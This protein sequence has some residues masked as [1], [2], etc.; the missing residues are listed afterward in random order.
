MR[1]ARAPLRA[2]PALLAVALAACTSTG[3]SPRPDGQDSAEDAL[4]LEP[5]PPPPLAAR[6]P[7]LE[8]RER[9]AELRVFRFELARDET[10]RLEDFDGEVRVIASEREVPEVFAHLG[11]LASSRETAERKLADIRFE[12]ALEKGERVLRL[13]E[14]VDERILTHSSYDVW[15]PFGTRVR[16]DTSAGG[17]RLTGPLG[18]CAVTASG[19][20][21]HVTDVRGRLIVR[22]SAEPVTIRSVE[23]PKLRV[24]TVHGDVTLESMSVVD[25][26][27]TTGSGDVRASDVRSTTFVASTNHGNVE[28]RDLEA[29][30]GART[31]S[32]TV[33]LTKCA[34]PRL[35][36]ETEFGDVVARDVVGRL[37]VHS[38]SGRIQVES[39]DGTVEAETN[40]GGVAV[41]GRLRAVVARSGS[42]DV[43]VT[44]REGS[45]AEQPWQ[46]TSETGDVSL[47]VPAAF[48][49]AIEARSGRGRIVQGVP[50]EAD[51][52]LPIRPDVVQGTLGG[53][54]ALVRLGAQDGRVTI[55]ENGLSRAGSRRAD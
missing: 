30:L 26:E 24:A 15:V 2:A 11:V 36:V 40:V 1:P 44:A 50:I 28:L 33:R 42:G 21:I 3:G 25:V 46:L 38:K 9:A 18:A 54:G 51:A 53:G 39:L 7:R 41:E 48:P 17:A 31:M 12:T 32:G 13:L 47:Y 35:G 6:E 8:L 16:L 5:A 14:P 4:P 37:V 27:V 22:G 23:G 10:L 52:R 43:S 45:A 55:A 29:T 20:P 49:C 34:G 19:G